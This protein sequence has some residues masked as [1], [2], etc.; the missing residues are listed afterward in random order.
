MTENSI[1]YQYKIKINIYN[2]I[3]EITLSSDTLVSELKQS[4][5]NKY[6]LNPNN[7]YIF[8]KNT[9]ITI[10]DFRKISS[11]FKEDKNPFIFIISAKNI[12]PDIRKDTT[13]NIETSL[14]EK[15]IS[16]I[17]NKFF[18]YKSMPFDANITTIYNGKYK[19]KFRK[20]LMASEF[21]QFY[22]INKKSNKIFLNNNFDLPKIKKFNKNKSMSDILQS[23]NQRIFLNRVIS[24]N[25]KSDNISEQSLESGLNIFHNS[26]QKKVNFKKKFINKSCEYVGMYSF[27][28]LNPD[29]KYNREKFLDKKNWIDKKG[30]LVRVGNNRMGNSFISNYVAATPSEPPLCHNFRDVQKNKWISKKGFI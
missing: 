6:L 2:K 25:R 29:E 4:I 18:E 5:L 23:N 19:I 12:L 30:F 20:P 27:P 28:F 11:L 16:E 9:K 8:Y 15:K 26:L 14:S 13:I 3:D 22:N 1:F 17:V 21:I 7:Y 24:S 10:N